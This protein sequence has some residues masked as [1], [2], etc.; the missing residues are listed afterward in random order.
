[1]SYESLML[2]KLYLITAPVLFVI[3]VYAII[4]TRNIIS[5]IIGLEIMT[6]GVTIL[7]AAAGFFNGRPQTIEPLI[8]TMIVVE[9]VILMI[10]SGYIINLAKKHNSL[11]VENIKKVKG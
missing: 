10:S 4:I 8:I 5:I 11:S 9:V 7:L 6:K 2:F 1:M 3:G